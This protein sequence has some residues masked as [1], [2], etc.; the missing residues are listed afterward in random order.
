MSIVA[1]RLTRRGRTSPSWSFWAVAFLGGSAAVA[2]GALADALEA[3]IFAALALL[4]SGFLVIAYV[5]DRRDSGAPRP[6]G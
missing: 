6:R 4:L 2:M 3:F 1:Y 5:L